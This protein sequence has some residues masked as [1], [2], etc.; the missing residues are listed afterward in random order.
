[1]IIS[2]FNNE[3]Y[4]MRAEMRQRCNQVIVVASS[5]KFGRN[6]LC[7]RNTLDSVDLIVSD[8]QLSPEYLDGLREREIEVLLAPL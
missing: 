3:E 4:T 6:G 5:E 2:N 8:N 7:T 1:M